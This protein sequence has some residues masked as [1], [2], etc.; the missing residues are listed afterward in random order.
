M[1]KTFI[2]PTVEVKSMAATSVICT[3]D[4]TGGLRSTSPALGY[5]GTTGANNILSADAKR[6][7]W[8]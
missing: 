6:I 7:S 4:V 1:K 5:G 8:D 3:S 2:A